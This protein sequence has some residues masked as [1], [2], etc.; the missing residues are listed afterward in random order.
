MYSRR[1]YGATVTAAALAVLGAVAAATA[2]ARAD[3]PYT[4]P[5]TS[6]WASF[7]P[8]RCFPYGSS[9]YCLTFTNATYQTQQG[10]LASTIDTN[11]ILAAALQD[12]RLAALAQRWGVNDP[13]FGGTMFAIGNVAR[14]QPD[15]PGYAVAQVIAARGSS[16]QADLAGL[17]NALTNDGSASPVAAAQLAGVANLEVAGSM[18]AQTQLMAAQVQQNTAIARQ[19]VRDVGSMLDVTNPDQTAGWNF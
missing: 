14:E 8:D 17:L 3:Y 15:N 6:S 16:W 18:Q 12:G 9:Q 7:V 19:A 10:Q 13:S 2:P 5:S 4:P 1:S 11:Q